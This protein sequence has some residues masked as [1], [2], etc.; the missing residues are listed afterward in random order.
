MLVAPEVLVGE[1]QQVVGVAPL[2]DGPKAVAQG[3]PRL[4]EVKG[5]DGA[6]DRVVVRQPARVGRWRRL[7]QQRVDEVVIDL[8]R[9]RGVLAQR[10]PRR[11]RAVGGVV[12]ERHLESGRLVEHPLHASR[13]GIDGAVEHHRPDPVGVR[14]G[15]Q[16]TDL[17]AVGVAQVGQLLVT[18]G[19]AQRIEVL[20]DVRRAYGGEEVDARPLHAGLHVPSLPCLEPRH[21]LPGCSRCPNYRRAG[22]RR[23]GRRATRRAPRWRRRRWAG[24]GMPHSPRVEPDDVE[25]FA[26]CARKLR[27]EPGREVHAVTA[28]ATRI[29]HQRTEFAS[30]GGDLD[31]RDRCDVTAELRVVDRHG[32]VC[33]P[34]RAREVVGGHP[35][36]ATVP[37]AR[38]RRR[39]ASGA[40]ACR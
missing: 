21:A 15:E 4:R 17:R 38:V 14:L 34:R 3:R 8:H 12:V 27:P 11:E 2:L 1:H 23:A 36:G 16:C 39:Q 5:V 32:Q 10:A 22:S 40:G 26:K 9:L 28:G 25:T 6:R 35:E 29:H 19:V 30:R 37:T 24:A 13:R 18:E 7:V 20:D 33:A 31:H